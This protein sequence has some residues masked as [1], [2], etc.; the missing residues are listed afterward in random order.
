MPRAC[1]SVFF[2]EFPEQ[3]ISECVLRNGMHDWG[4]GCVV[5]VSSAVDEEAG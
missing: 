4:V 1:V 2:T 5:S 3:T